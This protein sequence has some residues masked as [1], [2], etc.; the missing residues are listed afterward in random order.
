MNSTLELPKN[1]ESV[2]VPGT[3]FSVSLVDVTPDLARSWL[4]RNYENNR[5]VNGTNLARIEDDIKAGQWQVSHQGIAFDSQ[6]RLIDGQHRLMAI[7]NTG[8]TVACLVWRDIPFD[9]FEI[10][11]RGQKRDYHTILQIK[12]HKNDRSFH[13]A[14]RLLTNFT[15][16]FHRNY[17]P[18]SIELLEETIEVYGGAIRSIQSQTSGASTSL[19]MKSSQFL[20]ACLLGL[21]ISAD[22]TYTFIEQYKEGFGIEKGASTGLLRDFVLSRANT[23][24]Q[25]SSSEFFQ[26]AAYCLSK[27]IRDQKLKIIQ[28]SNIQGEVEKFLSASKLCPD[29]KFH[30]SFLSANS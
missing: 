23:V 18:N 3:E 24:N 27:F 13:S 30:S 5:N 25:I 12:G 10:T 26:L 1:Q 8:I 20:F 11:D 4:L 28:R 14:I 21:Q 17:I 7:A 15:K 19:H 29:G 16:G 22:K 2:K 9:V 6:G